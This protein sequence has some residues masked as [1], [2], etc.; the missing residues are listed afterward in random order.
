MAQCR[1][2]CCSA[3]CVLASGVHVAA[4]SPTIERVV[5]LLAS[6][7][8]E[9]LLDA[10]RQVLTTGADAQ[11]ETMAVAHDGTRRWW[12]HDVSALRGRDGKIMGISALCQDVTAR[13]I[14]DEQLRFLARHDPLTG[15]ANRAQLAERLEA[16]VREVAPTGGSVAAWP[17]D[18]SAMPAARIFWRVWAVMNLW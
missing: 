11:L 18:C 1:C 15:L 16:L 4:F 9:R 8:P 5:A 3:G 6:E 17:G 10:I 13:K 14:D 12:W 2:G 7:A